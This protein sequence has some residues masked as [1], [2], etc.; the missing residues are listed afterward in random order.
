MILTIRHRYRRRV[1]KNPSWT[2][3]VDH[4]QAIK[5]QNVQFRPTLKRWLPQPQTAL[6][7]DLKAEV[8]ARV[9]V[10]KIAPLRCQLIQ[11]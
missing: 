2:L 3:N 1:T 7:R 11:E 6:R 5:A 8:L 4:S 9:P 10:Q